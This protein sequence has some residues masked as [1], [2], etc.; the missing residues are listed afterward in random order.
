MYEALTERLKSTDFPMGC[1]AAYYFA[2]GRHA[3][4]QRKGSGFPYFVHPRGV[5]YIVMEHGGTI[6]QI[7]AAFCHDLLEDTETSYL[8]IA[9]VC[10]SFAV[11][12]ICSELRNN[13]IK[14][15]ELDG[16]KC[17]YMSEKLLNMSDDALLV[18]LADMLYNI[19]DNPAEKAK[20]RMLKNAYDV[21]MQRELNTELKTLAREIFES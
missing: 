17:K 20:V 13:K 9:T 21:I 19:N 5:A 7:N 10:N 18:K 6:E 3:H 16:D 14:I 11:A 8:E 2:K 1:R 12:D 4:Q 15:E